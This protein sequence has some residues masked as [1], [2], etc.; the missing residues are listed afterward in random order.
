MLRI[1]FLNNE[2]K[3]FGGSY[4]KNFDVVLAGNR[5]FYYVKDLVRELIS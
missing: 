4:K 2:M 1:G 5:D 3:E